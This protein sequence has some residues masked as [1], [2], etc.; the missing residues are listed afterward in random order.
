MIRV[1]VMIAVTGFLVSVVTLS[2]AVAIGGPELLTD[3]AWNGWT[4]RHF[5]W[6]RDFDDRGWNR[7]GAD[8]KRDIAWTGGDALTVEIPAEVRYTQ[9]SGPAKLTITGPQRELDNLVLE[10]GHLRFTHGRRHWDNLVVVMT[11][12]NVTRFDITGSGK[13]SIEG[14]RQ[15]RLIVDLSGD[16]SVEAR[17]EVKSLEL[18]ISGSGES[19]LSALNVRDA[20]VD[21]DG[22]G[23]A[24]LA[25]TGAANINIS[26]SGEVTLLSHPAKLESN[27]SGSGSIHQRDGASAG[28]AAPEPPAAP[29]PPRPP[30]PART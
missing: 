5:H 3:A 2:T 10:D 20:K 18:S 8:G 23:E 21:I 14:Y 12:P 25:P 29:K 26:G 4:G 6:D 9:G 16:G 28:P 11:A 22:S 7:G 24:T 19:D 27:V 13:L 15:D 17:G 30:R 1:L